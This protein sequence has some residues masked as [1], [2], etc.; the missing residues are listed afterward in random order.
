[1][2]TPESRMSRQLSSFRAMKHTDGSS[3][4]K[5]IE[6]CLRLTNWLSSQGMYVFDLIWFD[7]CMYN[8]FW[9]LKVCWI[10]SMYCSCRYVCQCVHALKRL[11]V[12]T[13][14]WMYKWVSLCGYE[15][16]PNWRIHSERCFLVPDHN[17][18]T[19]YFSSW[20]FNK[21]AV[22]LLVI[23]QGMVCE[24]AYRYVWL[25]V[26]VCVCVRMCTCVCV[27]VLVCVCGRWDSWHR[28]RDGGTEEVSKRQHSEHPTFP[29]LSHEKHKLSC[30][31][32]EW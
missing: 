23:A 15:F 28:L 13:R 12:C 9:D 7:L 24:C 6:T 19:G 25:C 2:S 27:Y 8:L 5:L 17:Y 20:H 4:L 1:M 11:C 29:A 22:Q 3:L 31:L 26:C 32:R 21:Q 14:E 10:A 18:K 16:F 30:L